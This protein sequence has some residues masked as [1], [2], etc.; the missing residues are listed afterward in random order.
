MHL[1]PVV[2]TLR[3]TLVGIDGR[4]RVLDMKSR[5]RLKCSDSNPIN[6]LPAGFSLIYVDGLWMDFMRSTVCLFV[7]RKTCYVFCLFKSYRCDRHV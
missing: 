3:V 4:P 7:W 5:L 1:L 2:Q 6:F